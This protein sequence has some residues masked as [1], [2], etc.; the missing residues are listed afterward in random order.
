MNQVEYT[1]LVTMIS[2]LKAQ[3]AGLETMVA[4]IANVSRDQKSVQ[5]PGVLSAKDSNSLSQDE[6][7]Y[8]E[9]VVM[10]ARQNELDRMSKSAQEYFERNIQIVA[11]DTTT[12]ETNGQQ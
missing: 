4:T 10:D 3:L 12:G 2:S 6:D 11:D 9:S 1:A 8:L 7:D 5:M